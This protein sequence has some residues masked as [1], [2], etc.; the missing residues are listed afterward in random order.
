MTREAL[1]QLLD[2]FP[3]VRTDLMRE[4]AAHVN[5]ALTRVCELTTERVGPRLAHS[6]L[7][8]MQS[9]GEGMPCP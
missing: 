5:D 7:R 1:G 9:C 6:L 4:M 2:R 8:L 3:Q